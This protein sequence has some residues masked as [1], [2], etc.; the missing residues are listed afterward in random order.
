MSLLRPRSILQLTIFS[1]LT[2][3]ALLIAA[4]VVTARQLD[5]LSDHSQKTISEA[6]NAM[7]TSR[8]LIEQTIAMERNARQ[9]SVLGAEE[10]L[11]VYVDRRKEF[12]EAA[13]ILSSLNINNE[14][15]GYA[16]QIID[17]EQRAFEKIKNTSA[18]EYKISLYPPL[19]VTAYQTSRAIDKWI[20]D[21]LLE[22]RQQTE[23]TQHLLR[24]QTLLLV[25]IALLLAALFTALITRPL[26]Q[27]DHAINQLGSGSYNTEIK[28][29][30]PLDLQKLG[31][32]LDWLRNRLAE[33]EHQ[34]TSFLRHVSHELKTPLT[35]IQEGVALLN[36]GLVGALTGQQSDIINILRNNCRRLQ[37][38]I[39]NLLRYHV[40]SLAVLSPMPQP[41]RFDNIINRVISDHELAIKAGRINIQRQLA[42]LTVQGDAEQL[43]IV[44]D[45][46]IANAVKYSPME[47][48][49]D[50][51][52]VRDQ[53][54]AVLEVCDD[55]PGIRPEER[56]MIF[57]PFYQG[58]PPEK[59]HIQGTGLGLAIASEYVKL[60]GGSL[61]AIDAL[62]GAHFKVQ[63][64]LAIKESS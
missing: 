38:L 11:E 59:K 44:T 50:I 64:P 33:L 15:R 26:R 43:R 23:H 32:R 17:D 58:R 7:R 30:G 31:I 61:E 51:H 39:E 42:K 1:F 5:N 47:G 36:E 4:L 63:F 8:G 40:D 62:H 24:I 41:V 55:G 12:L 49:I 45:N 20:D 9:Y 18:D 28:V 35:A 52:L 27:I 22:L 54:H 3:T 6:T 37:H 25:S 16:Q 29:Q 14:V 34:R 48:K 60:N 19:L 2:V 57:E 46:L 10:L 56:T 21:Q 53:D 13:S